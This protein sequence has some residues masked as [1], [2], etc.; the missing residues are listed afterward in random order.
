VHFRTETITSK[1]TWFTESA[2]WQ[3]RTE[4]FLF[5]TFVTNNHINFKKLTTCH[6]IQVNHRVG[7]DYIDGLLKMG[8]LVELWK[9]FWLV[10]VNLTYLENGKDV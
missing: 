9:E 3:T 7:R 2:D 6:L 1:L 8:I 10:T 4:L 5:V